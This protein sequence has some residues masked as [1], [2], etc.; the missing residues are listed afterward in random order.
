MNRTEGPGRAMW[1]AIS[2]E[3]GPGIRSVAL[4]SSRNSCSPSQ[5]RRFT[6]SACINAMCAAGPPNAVSPNMRKR[7]AT[8]ITPR[9]RPD[10]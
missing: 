4:T 9:L 3:L 5:L 6:T 8:S 10:L 2:V 7:A 1:I